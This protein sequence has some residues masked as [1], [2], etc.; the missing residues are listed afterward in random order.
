MIWYFTMVLTNVLYLVEGST[1]EFE[2]STT[3]NAMR[4]A[5]AVRMGYCSAAAKK[6]LS[7]LVP[8]TEVLKEM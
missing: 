7:T 4:S 1:S 2:V 3:E 6:M 5:I 8:V